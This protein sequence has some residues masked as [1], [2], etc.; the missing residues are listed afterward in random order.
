[1]ATLPKWVH[2]FNA[3]QE[4]SLSIPLINK[5]SNPQINTEPAEPQNTKAVEGDNRKA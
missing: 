2:R 4:K 3:I 1:M 5:E